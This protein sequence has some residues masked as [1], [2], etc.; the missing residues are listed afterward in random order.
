MVST[1]MRPWAAG[2]CLAALTLL[3]GCGGGESPA[4]AV[5]AA[6]LS[7][8]AALG[9]KIFN[10][11]SL[12]ASGTQSCAT[13]HDPGH[14]HAPANDLAAQFGGPHGDLQGPRSAPSLRYLARNT[15]FFFAADGTPTGG[16]FWDGRAPTLA[17]QAGEPFVNPFEMANADPAAVIARARR[18][19]VCGRV[20][21]R[22]S[23]TGSSTTRPAPSC[24]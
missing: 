7:A 18:G 17:E 2:L 21:R 15:A 19:A 22:S 20:P 4:A 12:S 8:Q 3:N 6:P 23:V 10:D 13:C 11:P 5:A 1:G 14:G 9:E 16:F 24:A